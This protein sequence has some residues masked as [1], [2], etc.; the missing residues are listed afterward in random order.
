MVLLLNCFETRLTP[1]GNQFGLVLLNSQACVAGLSTWSTNLSPSLAAVSMIFEVISALSAFL[2][3]ILAS[4]GIVSNLS[5]KRV[6]DLF[7][8]FVTTSTRPML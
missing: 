7:T 6:D 8:S 2:V 3:R 4:S 1:N 5:K